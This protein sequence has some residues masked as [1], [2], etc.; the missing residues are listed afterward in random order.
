MRSLFLLRKGRRFVKAPLESPSFLL[1]QQ[2]ARQLEFRT[3]EENCQD[4]IGYS[5]NSF[6]SVTRL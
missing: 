4:S 6:H 2:R 3:F 1:T 5:R